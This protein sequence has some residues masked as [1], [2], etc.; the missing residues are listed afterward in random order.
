[1]YPRPLIFFKTAFPDIFQ[2]LKRHIFQEPAPPPLPLYYDWILTTGNSVP[3]SLKDTRAAPENQSV[4]KQRTCLGS[5][6][7]Q[8][9]SRQADHLGDRFY[10]QVRRRETSTLHSQLWETAPL[11]SD[12]AGPWGAFPGQAA[13]IPSAGTPLWRTGLTLDAHRL[14]CSTAVKTPPNEDVNY[15]RTRSTRLPGLWSPGTDPVNACDTTLCDLPISQSEA[16]ARAD[17]R[18]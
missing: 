8:K 17:P 9:S 12:W 1:M 3:S 10:R 11:P 5:W 2:G 6:A 14:S 13:P 16:C 7:P 4:R 15:L 18:L